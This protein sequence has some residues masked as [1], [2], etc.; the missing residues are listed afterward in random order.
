MAGIT[1]EE[2][3]AKYP[4]ADRDE[5]DRAY[6][7]ASLAGVIAD[8]EAALWEIYKLS[9]ADTDGD[10]GPGALIAGMGQA[11]FAGVVATAVLELRADYEHLLDEAITREEEGG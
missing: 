1:L 4:P 2:L 6:A 10:E 5:Y 11:G 3:Q 9:G 7:A 8:Y